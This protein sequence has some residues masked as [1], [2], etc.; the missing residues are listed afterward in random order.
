[1]N[2][3]AKSNQTSLEVQQCPFGNHLLGSV[4]GIPSISISCCK[5]GKNQAPLS[6]NQPISMGSLYWIIIIP[7][8]FCS[9]GIIHYNH[10]PTEV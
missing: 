10:Q 3:P 1:M 9:I 6:I 8:V 5:I 4:T 2:N 7:N